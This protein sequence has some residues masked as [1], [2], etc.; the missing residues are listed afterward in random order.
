MQVCE[1]Y[2]ALRLLCTLLYDQNVEVS[3]INQTISF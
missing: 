2:T 1:R 3:V